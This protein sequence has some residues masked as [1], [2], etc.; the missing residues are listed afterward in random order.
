MEAARLYETV[1]DHLAALVDGG[2]LLPGDRLP[3]VRRLA[4]QQGVSISTV[5]Q[6]Y[7]LLEARGRIEV[8][9]KSGHY[10][11]AR[12]RAALPE[13]RT[14]KVEDVARPVTI[15]DRVAR[16]NGAT[17][18]IPGVLGIAVPHASLLPTDKLARSAAQAA[19]RWGAAAISY[20]PPAGVPILRQELARRSATWG[21]AIPAEGFLVTVGAM[22]A[23]Q[24]ALRAVAGRGDAIA[25]E[26]PAFFGVLQLIQSLGLKVVEIPA[27]AG[28]GMDLARLD[29]ALR[30]R[31]IRAVL[32]VPSFGNP[33]GSL[34]PDSARKELVRIVTR[35]DVPLVEDDVYGDLP[36][37]GVRPRLARSFDRKGLV[38]VCSSVSKTL[39][40]GYRI[41]WIAPGRYRAA[42]ERLKS[43]QSLT[44]PVL[45]QLAIAEFLR[46]GGY[47]HHLRGLRRRLRAQV[48]HY[49]AEI[50]ARFPAG[51]R[52]S[53]PKGG[54]VLWVELPRGVDSL[55]LQERAAKAG[56]AI[57]PGPIFTASGGFRNFLRISCG[58]PWTPETERA[59]EAVAGIATD[60]ARAR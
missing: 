22:E 56:A 47:D 57:A 27:H 29:A 16:L 37:D 46:T 48:E 11:K 53:R 15:A 31:K 10:V 26:T 13:P 1:A 54:F 24:L 36:F 43:A 4:A 38:L 30:R 3:S 39:A 35:H 6:A 58:H 50:A 51:T 60:L 59:V 40:P 12:L 44:S 33:L 8:R 41:G 34:M 20:G 19:R 45:P 32:A 23:L 7:L 55:D 17:D 28:T 25:V 52:L 42:V 21:C 9:P 49:S 2:S 14:P 18:G 5:L